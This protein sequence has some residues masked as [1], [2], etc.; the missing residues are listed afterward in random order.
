MTRSLA[1]CGTNAA[2]Q[3][4]I[5]HGEAACDA[6]VRARQEYQSAYYRRSHPDAQPRG[7][8]R[9][10]DRCPPECHVDREVIRR[11]AVAKSLLYR[12]AQLRLE[13]QAAVA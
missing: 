2:Y 13:D 7:T 10:I 6:C 9:G 3:R 8:R 12:M 11:G 4:H 1:P 5:K